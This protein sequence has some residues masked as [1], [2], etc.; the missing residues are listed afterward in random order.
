[1]EQNVYDD[2]RGFISFP[3]GCRGNAKVLVYNNTHGRVSSPCPI[4]GKF[5]IFNYDT[6]AAEPAPM[7]KGAIKNFIGIRQH[8]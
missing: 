4:C 7:V 5:A 2:L 8:H 1:M 3:C 6:M